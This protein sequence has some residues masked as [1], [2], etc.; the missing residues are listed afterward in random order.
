MVE[1][2]LSV[3]DKAPDF[4]IPDPSGQLKCLKDFAGKWLVLYFYPKDNTPGCT[5]EAIDFSYL[6]DDFLKLNA[7]ICGISKDSCASHQK[8]MDK[9][10]LTIILLSDN[11]HTVQEAYGVWRMKKFM[12]RDFMGTIRSTFLI[13]PDGVIA[14][15]W[16]NVEV[17][18]HALSV[19]EAIK[20]MGD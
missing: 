8:F 15:I 14:R 16:D 12:G 3:G 5:I 1:V 6:R 9:K 4:R 7:V 20:G 19:L 10:S 2:V 18:D 11:D 13:G 17:A